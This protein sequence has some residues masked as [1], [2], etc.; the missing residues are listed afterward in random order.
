[1]DKDQ[2]KSYLE[3]GAK[4]RQMVN[5]EEI[6]EISL[7]V[8]DRLINKGGTLIIFGN[9]GSAA[10]AQH[11]AEEFSCYCDR[12]GRRPLAAVALTASTPAITAI[13]NDF[14]FEEVFSRQV[15]GL[16]KENDVVIG[17]ST[18]GKAVNVL[19]GIE[20]ANKL[21]C[22]TIVLTGKTAGKLRGNADRII[23]VESA[24]TP[25]IQEIHMAIGHLMSKIVEDLIDT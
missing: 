16:A 6:Y 24:S 8:A 25:I 20:E 4:L 2:I 21:G 7:E 23:R 5:A 14:S 19:K 9:G 18:S 13:A 3:E 10:D 1:M 12:R 15:R 22:F 11:I 17:I